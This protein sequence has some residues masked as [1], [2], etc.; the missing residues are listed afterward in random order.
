[1]RDDLTDDE[2]LRGHLLGEL[3]EED[4]ER[5]ERRLLAEDDLFE[6]SE[7]VEADLLAACDR[8][9]LT[10]AERERVLGRLASSPAGRERLALARGLNALAGAQANHP[11]AAVLPF[12]GRPV[13]PSPT[14][15]AFRWAAL[16]AG[17][18]VASGLAWF[19][20]HPQH[21]G[22]SAP[23]IARE[24]PAPARPVPAPEAQAQ[25]APA[26]PA[27]KPAPEP[28]KS[29]FQLALTSLRGSEAPEKLRVRAGTRDVELQISV[30]E[31]TGLQ[32]FQVAVRNQAGE[33]LWKGR[34]EPATLHGVRVVVID[35]PAE[36]LPAGMYEITARGLTPG[37]EP[38]DLSPL[39]VEVVKDGNR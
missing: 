24:V 21:G 9:E 10:A 16:A 33:T 20:L 8:G 7:A 37:R 26:P 3:P 23:W 19:A 5:L 1:M 29:V 15:P 13:A 36:R 27:P 17:V 34:R 18:L 6:L 14:R 39:N 35:L 28:V 25:A 4:A 11:P 38:E 2:L 12:K 30:E 31:M 32:S 22:E